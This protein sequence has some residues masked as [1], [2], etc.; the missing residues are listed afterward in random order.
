[1]A[2]A[3]PGEDAHSEGRDSVT[4]FSFHNTKE[5]VKEEDTKALTHASHAI[6]TDRDEREETREIAS[7]GNQFYVVFLVFHPQSPSICP[8]S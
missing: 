4:S 6:C 2:C 5:L 8:A 3:T 7:D 1:M